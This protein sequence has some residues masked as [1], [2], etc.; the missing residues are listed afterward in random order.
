MA[1]EPKKLRGKTPKVTKNLTKKTG[2]RIP[3]N[4]NMKGGKR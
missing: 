1:R 2:K 3:T 4:E